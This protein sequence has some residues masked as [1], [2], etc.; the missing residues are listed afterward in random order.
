MYWSPGVRGNW[1]TEAAGKGRPSNGYVQPGGSLPADVPHDLQ[2]AA[3][4]PVPGINAT[5]P[6]AARKPIA[7]GFP[8]YPNVR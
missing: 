1:L 7:P 6:L 5:Q 2:K 3:S 8:H 4:G